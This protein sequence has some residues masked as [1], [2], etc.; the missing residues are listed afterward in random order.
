[1]S[2]FSKIAERVGGLD[3]HWMITEI[4]YQFM[5]A[6]MLVLSCTTSVHALTRSDTVS[7]MFQIG[8]QSA[9]KL[10][11]SNGTTEYPAL[12][13]VGVTDDEFTNR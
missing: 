13:N 3:E 5:S 4:I 2:V 8:K 11:A 1:M 9:L 6:K 12:S 10:L 7:S